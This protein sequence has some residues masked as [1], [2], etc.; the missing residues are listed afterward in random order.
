MTKF[1]A[2]N[3]LSSILSWITS[4]YSARNINFFN[5]NTNLTIIKVIV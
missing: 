1:V 3:I 5:W 4:C 2:V